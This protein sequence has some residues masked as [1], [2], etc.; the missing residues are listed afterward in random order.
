M[1]GGPGQ[2]LADA[3]GFWPAASQSFTGR[4]LLSTSLL[5]ITA[6]RRFSSR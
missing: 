6:P 2:E 1:M 4:D 5:G 3:A